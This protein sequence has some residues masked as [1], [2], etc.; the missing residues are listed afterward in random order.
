MPTNFYL[1]GTFSQLEK[2]QK[3]KDENFASSMSS[4]A[5]IMAK[6]NGEQCSWKTSN[7]M[8]VNINCSIEHS[9]AM[10]KSI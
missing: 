5:E 2:Q 9:V 8:E 4:C 3:F 10:E 6:I 1:M 7:R